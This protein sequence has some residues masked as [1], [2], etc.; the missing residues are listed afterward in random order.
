MNDNL[1]RRY[2]MLLRVQDFGRQHAASFPPSSLGSQLFLELEVIIGEIEQLASTQEARGRGSR[3]GTTNRGEA[4]MALREDL[5]TISD[6]ARAMALSTA[7]LEDKFRL[8]RGRI[9]D[10]DLLSIARAFAAD[11]LPLKDEFIR[12]EMPANFLD[13]LNT[14]IAAFEQA[15]DKQQRSQ[16]ERV[17]AAEGLGDRVERG[18]NKVRQITPVVRNKFRD[19]PQT[20]SEW[21]SA[22]HVERAPASK[23]DKPEEPNTPT[24]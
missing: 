18:V 20:L 24:T 9:N 11:A 1:R 22:S 23:P 4:R 5:D 6:T 7:G 21:E 12:H 15:I 13:E 2:E 17:S 8:P 14:H 19:N 10:V 16:R 3:E